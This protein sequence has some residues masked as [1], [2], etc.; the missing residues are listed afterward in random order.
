MTFDDIYCEFQQYYSMYL[1]E[2]IIKVRN[3]L[4]IILTQLIDMMKIE[5]NNECMELH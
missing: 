3:E 5:W 1:N 2:P 4:E